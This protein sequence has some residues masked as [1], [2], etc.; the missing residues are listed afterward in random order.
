MLEQIIT[1]RSVPGVHRGLTSIILVTSAIWTLAIW[2][3]RAGLVEDAS[4]WSWTRVV[5]SLAFGGVLLLIRWGWDSIGL[6]LRVALMLAYGGWMM[7]VWIPSLAGVLGSGHSF[8]FQAVHTGLAVV[9]LLSGAL[10]AGI[11]RRVAFYPPTTTST[12]TAANNAAK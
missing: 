7:I 2:G 3:S 12:Q 8:G 1:P 6:R 5:V 9:S 11:A 4:A 10:I